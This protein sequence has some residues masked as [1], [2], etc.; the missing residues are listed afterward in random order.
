MKSYYRSPQVEEGIRNVILQNRC[1]NRLSLLVHER[2][3]D[4]EFLYKPNAFRRKDFRARNFS[5]RDNCTAIF[6]AFSFPEIGAAMVRQWD[7]DPFI[8]R[9]GI[10]AEGGAR[11]HLTIVNVPDENVFV[12][13]A[14]C[15]LLLAL[16]PHGRFEES[17]GLLQERF[18][19][20]GEEIVSFVAFPGFEHNRFRLTDDGQAVLQ[21]FENDCILIG[22]EENDAQVERVCRKL[23]GKTIQILE[24]ETETCL[25]PVLQQGRMTLQADDALQRVLDVNRRMVWSGL[26]A[27][28]ACFGALN[29][30]YHLIWT[31]DGSM[32]ASALARAG[33]PDVVETWT[34]FLLANPS[35]RLDD[36][37]RR[38]REFLQLVGT[39]W[40][41][42]EDDGIYYAVLSLFT[43]A[44][45]SGPTR[46]LSDGTLA[47][48][49]DILDHTIATRFDSER[50]LFGSDTL[51]EDTLAGSPY[52]GYD[53]VNGA[54]AASH[55]H[56]A[57]AP[58]LLRVF[59][60][61]Q[62]INMYN[63]LMMAQVLISLTRDPR[64]AEKRE[65]YAG[66]A[67]TLA[68]QLRQQFVNETGCYR[69][70]CVLTDDGRETWSDTGDFWEY[71]W[72]VSAGPFFPDPVVALRS[73]R[74]TVETWPTLKAYGYCPWNFL[75]S[76]LK[77][78]GLSTAGY[79]EML[80]QQVREALTVST[81]YPMPGL[82]TEYQ[83]NIEGWRGLP[84][85]AGSLVLS[86]CSLLVRAL[87][88]G[89]AVRASD[90]VDRVESYRWRCSCL[91]VVAEGSGD[92][93][94][95]VR[96]N[97]RRLEGTLQLPESWLRMGRNDI[98]AER[99]VYRGGARLVAS[100][101]MLLDVQVN[102][103]SV[104]YQLSCPVAAD[105]IFEGLDA[106]TTVTVA[107]AEGQETLTLRPV[108]ESGKQV[109]SIPCVGEVTLVVSRP[110]R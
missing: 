58:Q 39:R 91:D 90:L 97:N 42:T 23:A 52:F 1:G 86:V 2:H 32:T 62:N 17:D 9:L 65:R 83:G 77:E 20:R 34:P 104:H 99:G 109:A 8:L 94:A 30:I 66:L 79:R 106:S 102:G 92:E 44:Q 88:L 68:T 59:S 105:V 50:G 107:S 72:A 103:T 6:P 45:A 5:S 49:L 51:G 81:K 60:L 19:D 7:Y 21:I 84:F 85:G 41:K 3:T 47:D 67:R 10:E 69:S 71:A 11:N 43:L 22:A 63:C 31:R 61:Y 96:V 95:G 24:Q 26:D 27:G 16:R 110:G 80:D 25:A 29:R 89:L 35:E 14:R 15:P 53:T 76:I 55:Q 101:A 100:S 40:T 57:G 28:G 56:V 46:L 93:V 98:V 13:S 73:A 74:K 70:M 37:G 82:V 36:G 38:V 87:P 108:A 12:V 4:L 64:H 18:R 78:Y 54:F 48:V 33:W 75:A